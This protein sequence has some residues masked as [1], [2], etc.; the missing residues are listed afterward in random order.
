MIPDC[1][2]E[3]MARALANRGKPLEPLVVGREFFIADRFYRLA[4]ELATVGDHAELD[5]AVA[6]NLFGLDIDLD[7][8]RVG[9]NQRVAPAGEQSDSGAERNHQVRAAGGAAMSGG[10]NRAE[11]AEAQRMLFG[12]RPARLRVGHH[13]RMRQ[14][15]ESRELLGRLREPHAAARE[16]RGPPRLAQPSQRLAQS[17]A[18][19]AGLRAGR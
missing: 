19:R 5:I 15:G 10:M 14:L 4:Q 2:V 13:R 9:R 7:H 18:A 11:S 8:A 17:V 1:V 3:A 6:S 12:N 16:H